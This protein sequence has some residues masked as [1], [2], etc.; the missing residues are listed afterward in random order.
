MKAEKLLETAIEER[1]QFAD[2]YAA[3]GRCYAAQWKTEEAMEAYQR[4][5]QL[6][7]NLWE[8]HFELGNYYRDRKNY[9]KAIEHYT[10]SLSDRP[11]A[12]EIRFILARC[13]EKLET[14]NLL[15]KPFHKQ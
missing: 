9:Q 14:L 12:A 15:A 6:D 4:S 10:K 3:L 13:T 2:A 5:V 1:P 8:A 11:K 7:P